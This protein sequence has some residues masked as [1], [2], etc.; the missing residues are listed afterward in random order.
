MRAM[1][2][3]SPSPA[4]GSGRIT[5]FIREEKKGK[6]V[7]Q[8]LS[9]PQNIQSKMEDITYEKEGS[10]DTEEE[11]VLDLEKL[12]ETLTSEEKEYLPYKPE[13]DEEES[14]E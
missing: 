8:Y 9:F 7:Q 2:C 6:K 14:E 10:E 12:A 11:T 3:V 13:E 5:V 1:I 4:G